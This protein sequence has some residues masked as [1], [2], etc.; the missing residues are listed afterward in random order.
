ME[1]S[2]SIASNA[3]TVTHLVHMASSEMLQAAFRGTVYAANDCR[4]APISVKR[5]PFGEG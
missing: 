5:L 3:G 4:S 2:H 1:E